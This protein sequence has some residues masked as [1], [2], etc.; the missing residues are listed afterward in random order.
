M[1]SWRIYQNYLLLLAFAFKIV[2][3]GSMLTLATHNICMQRLIEEDNN[4]T[5]LLCKQRK[6]D[7][8]GQ[9]T[10]DASVSK[11]EISSNLFSFK[12]VV[13]P[14]AHFFRH[15]LAALCQLDRWP[16]LLQPV[17]PPEKIFLRHC[18][19]LT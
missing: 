12:D 13:L 19:L 16:V 9:H 6:R 10:Q 2:F 8:Q 14:V 3:I 11:A 4:L 5:R 1:K 7:E 17:Y 15:R 18:S